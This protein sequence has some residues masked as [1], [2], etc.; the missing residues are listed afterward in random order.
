MFQKYA[1]TFSDGM[2][3]REQANFLDLLQKTYD[4]DFSHIVHHGNIEKFLI[5]NFG[6]GSM[7]TWFDCVSEVRRYIFRWNVEP[8]TS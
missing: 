4:F 6:L 1:D 8:K 7:S 3:S 5:M 2:S